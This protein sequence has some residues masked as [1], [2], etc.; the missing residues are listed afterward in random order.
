MSQDF[1]LSK[2]CASVVVGNFSDALEALSNAAVEAEE[3][4]LL[5][6]LAKVELEI[7]DLGHLVSSS[8]HKAA[9]TNVKSLLGLFT[10]SERSVAAE[11]SSFIRTVVHCRTVLMACRYNLVVR[12][13]LQSDNIEDLSSISKELKSLMSFSDYEE[14]P[15]FPLLSSI[16]YETSIFHSLVTLNCHIDDCK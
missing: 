3:F 14:T 11:Y 4:R 1:F 7:A 16:Y 5:V 12:Q 2:Y 10:S 6:E 15:L 9:L 13:W 8:G